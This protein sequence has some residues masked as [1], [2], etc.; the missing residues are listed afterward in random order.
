[1]LYDIQPVEWFAE[2][3]MAEDRRKAEA[4]RLVNAVTRR[5]TDTFISRL[6]RLLGTSQPRSMPS[7][8]TYRSKP[9]HHIA[10]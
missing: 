6:F 2:T 9:A 3:R 5:D 7:T 10:R 1:M 8:R 4:Y